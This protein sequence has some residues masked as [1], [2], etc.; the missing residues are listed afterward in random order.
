M[1]VNSDINQ[2]MRSQ[3]V[4]QENGLYLISEEFFVCQIHSMSGKNSNILFDIISLLGLQTNFHYL[5]ARCR[6]LLNVI[7]EF[8]L[9]LNVNVM[10]LIYIT[11]L[12]RKFFFQRIFY[13]HFQRIFNSLLELED[14]LGDL[15][16]SR[17]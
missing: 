2:C 14:F 11:A 4:L 8:P 12:N 13:I 5:L 6:I 9:G 16:I 3:S 10:Y 17:N 7:K 15:L 1:K